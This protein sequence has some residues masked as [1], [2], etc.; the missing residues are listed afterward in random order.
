MIKCR[1]F[2][3]C[4]NS[5]FSI[6]DRARFLKLRNFG[7]FKDTG[8]CPSVSMLILLEFQHLVS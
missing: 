6:T 1:K 2:W 7:L 4:H 5:I 3:K 8:R